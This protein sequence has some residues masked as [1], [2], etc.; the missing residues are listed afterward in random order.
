M[1]KEY[2][3]SYYFKT[4]KEKETGLG[5]IIF[6]T[7]RNIKTRKN[8][9]ELEAEIAKDAGGIVCILNIIQLDSEE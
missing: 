2:L 3:V 1:E 5:R 4:E 7:N 9:K 6:S 8:I